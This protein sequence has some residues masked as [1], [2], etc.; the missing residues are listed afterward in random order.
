M[1]LSRKTKQVSQLGGDSSTPILLTQRS[2]HEQSIWGPAWEPAAQCNGDSG[3]SWAA[4]TQVPRPQEFGCLL[5]PGGNLGC[6]A[7]SQPTLSQKLALMRAVGPVSFQGCA[8]KQREGESS[9]SFPGEMLRMHKAKA[10]QPPLFH[11]LL[12]ELTLHFRLLFKCF[13]L[14]QMTYLPLSLSAGLP[15]A[16]PILSKSYLNLDL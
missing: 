2:S 14:P 10:S 15:R 6:L 5:C 7:Q 13:P 4:P 16:A 8:L 3:L 1:G 12:T 9:S 11:H